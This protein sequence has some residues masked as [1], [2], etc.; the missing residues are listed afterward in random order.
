MSDAAALAP[1]SPA[2]LDRTVACSLLGAGA[3]DMREDCFA[4]SGHRCGGSLATPEFVTCVNAY[5]AKFAKK[6]GVQPPIPPWSSPHPD[7]HYLCAHP[8]DAKIP[9]MRF[10]FFLPPGW[11]QVK[12]VECCV[13]AEAR[14]WEPLSL[15]TLVHKEVDSF[16]NSLKSWRKYGLLDYVDEAIV[17]INA[18]QEGEDPIEDLANEYG[19]RVVSASENIG[20][21]MALAELVLQAKHQLVM[22]LEK[23][24]EVVEP[25]HEVRK[26][27]DLTK[28]LLLSQVN[29]SR[30]D[31]V[32]L[33][34]RVKAGFPNIGHDLC[35]PPEY[36]NTEFN[37][38]AQ[39]R[40]DMVEEDE[41][42]W[43]LP[44]LY[45]N[46]YHFEADKDLMKKWPNRMWRCGCASHFWC[47][48]SAQCGWTN[49]PIVFRKHWFLDTLYQQTQREDNMHFE[50]GTYYSP[51]WIEP[52][53]VVAQGDGFFMHHEINEHM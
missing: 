21:G 9:Q 27:L 38:Y 6:A 17:F 2:V 16:N 53:W 7:A 37:Q 45:C 50:G 30:A 31:A 40:P 4:I 11:I 32:K 52:H 14:G 8:P 25:E 34:S 20:I 33:R 48:D 15:V 22:F 39:Y 42:P 47:Y 24:W 43:W 44:H 28:G 46:V 5:D 12:C 26:Q 29:G 1:C 36:D 49:N 51:E 3:C 10:E 19:L 13:A 41:N 18:K 23:D 35:I